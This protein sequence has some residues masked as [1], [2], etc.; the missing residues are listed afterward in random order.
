MEIE[1]SLTVTVTG[2]SLEDVDNGLVQAAGERLRARMVNPPVGPLGQVNIKA[3]TMAPVPPVV[4]TTVRQSPVAPA[5]QAVTAVAAPLP[6]APVSDKMEAQPAKR[7]GRPPRAKA[8]E[9]NHAY[10]QEEAEEESSEAGHT[11]QA[12]I[13]DHAPAA[14]KEVSAPAKVS[15][16]NPSLD[17]VVQALTRVNRRFD[18][19]KARGCLAHFNVKKCG[20]LA[21]SQRALFIQHCDGLV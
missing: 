17:D 18:I 21:D 2:K 20:E 3:P 10:A 14:P 7:R 5:V 4:N 19:D 8:E 9:Q 6:V 16:T 15:G 11:A 1:F 13:V 12:A